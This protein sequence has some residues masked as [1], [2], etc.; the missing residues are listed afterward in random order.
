MIFKTGEFVSR[1]EPLDILI[2]KFG[3][4]DRNTIG[5]HRVGARRFDQD[6][7]ASLCGQTPPASGRSHF[8]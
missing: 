5:L 4:I 6:K 1:H 8:L 3:T 7:V 2:A